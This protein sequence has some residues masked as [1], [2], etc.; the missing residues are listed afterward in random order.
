MASDAV[1]CGQV[2]ILPLYDSSRK[3]SSG[4]KIRYYV[5]D[6]DDQSTVGVKDDACG[7]CAVCGLLEADYLLTRSGS[8]TFFLVLIW[9]WQLRHVVSEYPARTGHLSP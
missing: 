6:G 5:F 9:A 3:T 4:S 8:V 2:D 7:S 1:L